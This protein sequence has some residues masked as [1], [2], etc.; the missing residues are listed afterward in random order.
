MASA[1][2]GWLLARQEVSAVRDDVALGPGGEERQMSLRA[3][4]RR[5]GV[6]GALQDDAR[7][8]DRRALGEPALDGVEARIA[9]GV[10]VAVPVGMDHHVDEVGIVE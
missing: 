10:A 9:R 1:I 7:H 6:L 3:A 5:H 8:R 2:G 4:R